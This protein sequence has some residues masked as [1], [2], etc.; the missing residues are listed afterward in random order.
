MVRPNWDEYFI[1]IMK[2]VAD[3]ATCDRGKSGAV[4]VKDNRILLTGYVGSPPGFDHCDE[5]G[6]MMKT[7]TH[8]D[9][10]KSNHCVRTI[11]AEQNIICHAAKF[12]IATEGSTL[13]CKMVPCRT[14][15]MLLIA[16]GIKRIVC[17]C[18]YHQGQ[19]SLLE[20]AGIEIRIMNDSVVEYEKQ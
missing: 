6:H 9:G 12:G 17:E 18:R 2:S 3:R 8:E 5:V 15:A 4:L 13:Y 1:G 19:E 14:C 7:V 16:C 11:H 10:S 20:K